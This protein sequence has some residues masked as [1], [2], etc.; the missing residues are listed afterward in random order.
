M[1]Q[2]KDC[3]EILEKF[4]Q[5]VDLDIGAH[6]A[7][8]LLEDLSEMGEDVCFDRNFQN[9]NSFKD[10]FKNLKRELREFLSYDREEYVD[11]YVDMW[12]PCRGKNG[13]PKRYSDLIEGA[14]Q[15]LD[16]HK[17][18]LSEMN[19]FICDLFLRN[20]CDVYE[21]DTEMN[22]TFVTVSYM[23]DEQSDKSYKESME[24]L[25][26]DSAE[27]C[28]KMLKDRIERTYIRTN[29]PFKKDIYLKWLSLIKDF[30]K[31]ASLQ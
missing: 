24:I 27:T 6:T 7:Y 13:V 23:A 15:N 4:C 18:W 8:V 11:E 14:E 12:A 2:E 17:R 20:F 10:I 22:A 26:D 30:E 21:R 28:F 19:N 16:I 9:V 25:G 5:K 3:K 1:L 31:E 29:D